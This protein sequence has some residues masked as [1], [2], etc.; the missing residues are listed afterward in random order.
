ML[1]EFQKLIVTKNAGR[2]LLIWV[3]LTFAGIVIYLIKPLFILNENQILYLFSSA[4]QVIAAIFG[5]IITGYIFLRNELDRK[6]DKDETLEEVILL[7]KSEYFGSITGIS[8]MTG[9]S[10]ALC[11]L[12]IVAETNQLLAPLS[13]LINISVSTILTTLI[14]IISFVIIILNPNSIEIASNKLRENTTTDKANESGSLENFLKNFNQIDYILEKYGTT[15]LFTDIDN[16]KSARRKRVAK[17]KLVSI[18]FSEGK[19]DIDL[20]NNLME[21]ITLRNSLV[22]GTDLFVSIND[23]QLSENLLNRLRSTLGVE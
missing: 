19:I 14:T 3:A 5:L 21:L 1:K 16:Y 12:V 6:A 8:I 18:L 2:N 22:H 10:I 13:L 7:L 20:R 15:L 4:S 11:F 23:V 17:T 9:I